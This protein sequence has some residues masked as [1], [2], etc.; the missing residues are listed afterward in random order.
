MESPTL[1]L[2]AESGE[3]WPQLR[4]LIASS[5]ISGPQVHDAR[6]AALC[7]QHGVR[8]LWSADRDFSRF[9]QLVVT[10]P[11]VER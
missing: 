6:I 4:T 5:R 2:L 7:L 3:H 9:P 1:V 11:L 10:N 8:E